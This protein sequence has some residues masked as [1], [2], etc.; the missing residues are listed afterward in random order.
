MDDSEY[1]KGYSILKNKYL[2]VNFIQE[3]DSSIKSQVL[4]IVNNSKDKFINFCFGLLIRHLKYNLF[5]T[6][7]VKSKSDNLSKG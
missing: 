4:D 6:I 3:N 7:S 2:D 5:K 1:Q